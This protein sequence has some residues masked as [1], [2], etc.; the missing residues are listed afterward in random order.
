MNLTVGRMLVAILIFSTYH[1]VKTRMIYVFPVRLYGALVLA[2]IV[3]RDGISSL[4]INP[5]AVFFVLFIWVCSRFLKAFGSGDAEIYYALL[6]YGLYSGKPVFEYMAG[7]LAISMALA[8]VVFG[9]GYLLFRGRINR[10]IPM[11]PYIFAA[12]VICGFVL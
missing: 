10:K 3:C 1:D 9:I 6:L 5:A 7:I 11:V 8:V 12:F 2:L 4:L